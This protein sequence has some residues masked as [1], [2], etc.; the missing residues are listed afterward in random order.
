MYQYP[1]PI[2]TAF[3]LLTFRSGKILEFEQGLRL[4]SSPEHHYIIH[5][6]LRKV[7]L[8]VIRLCESPNEKDFLVDGDHSNAGAVRLQRKLTFA[9]E[10]IN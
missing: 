3:T 2:A 8:E 6:A 7:S 4:G 1:A 10:S 9:L 5:Y